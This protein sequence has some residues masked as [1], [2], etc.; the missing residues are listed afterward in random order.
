VTPVQRVG[1]QGGRRRRV[2]DVLGIATVAAL[3]AAASGVVSSP[4]PS[5][6]SS[7]GLA[8][9]MRPPGDAP[10]V[11]LE[12]QTIQS[13]RQTAA[14]FDLTAGC[15]LTL[16]RIRGR[17]AAPG[18]QPL[19]P[20]FV[21]DA[22]TARPGGALTLRVHGGSF[23]PDVDDPAKSVV[24]VQV[25]D[26]GAGIAPDASCDLRI[27]SRAPTGVAFAIRSAGTWQVAITGC[28]L[29]AEARTCGV[30]WARVVTN[31]I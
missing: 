5:T 30:W 10:I 6:Q 14:M 21:R 29:A 28:A 25:V 23:V 19:L 24:C 3:F 18:C 17:D 4:P 8:A 31:P 13:G 1:S 26:A 16:T 12:Q 22:I 2:A 20:V 9:T 11:Y 27:F 7:P 15:W